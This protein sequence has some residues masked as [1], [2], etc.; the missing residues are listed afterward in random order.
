MVQAS[1]SA[2]ASAGVLAASEQQLQ[3]ALDL[4]TALRQNA[5]LLAHTARLQEEVIRL[6]QANARVRE[7]AFHDELTGLPNRTLLQDRFSQAIALA[8]RRG[9]QI[10]LLFLD[11]DHFKRINDEFGHLAGDRVLQQVAARLVACLRTSDTPCRYGGDEFVVLLPELESRQSAFAA[12]EKILAR[13]SV[14]YLMGDAAIEVTTSIGI[15]LYP[16]DGSECSELIRVSDH[17]MY[18]NKG[19]P[20]GAS[21]ADPCAPSDK[22]ARETAAR[23]RVSP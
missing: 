19:S 2:R 23:G 12:A 22:A 11:L 7:L 21:P 15:A 3:T 4:R 1:A 13:L 20:R 9:R 5:M 17:A 10:A 6:R 14:P 8:M 16:D 18:R